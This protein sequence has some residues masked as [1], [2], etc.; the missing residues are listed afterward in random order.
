MSRGFTGTFRVFA[1]RPIRA[2]SKSCSACT[3]SAIRPCASCATCSEPTLGPTY[4]SLSTAGFMA[5]TARSPTSSTCSARRGARS[6][7]CPT[8]TS[9][10]S[11]TISTRLQPRSPTGGSALSPASIPGDR[12]G[13]S[14]RGWRRSASTT[15]FCP[16]CWPAYVSAWPI[17][18][19]A[20]QSPCVA[21]CWR[22]SAV[23]PSW[24]TSLPT[25]TI[26]AAP[27]APP[28]IAAC[29]RLARSRTS[30]MSAAWASCGR[31]RR[32]GTAPSTPSIPSATWAPSSPTPSHGRCWAF[33]LRPDCFRLWPWR[34]RSARASIWCGK[35]T[36][37][38][39]FVPVRF[40]CFYYA[41]LSRSPCS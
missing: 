10:S 30:A 36:A 29:W 34:R 16:M 8:A 5:R 14:G 6:W 22:R 4:R 1:A 35:S 12:S 15:S 27:C 38:P 2:P 26:S 25:T 13:R 20:P 33:W 23:S 28:A 37:R 9:A 18:A 39:D 21:R 11:G 7:S 3:T 31:T 17:P 24:P 41:T 40:P 32:G 19:S